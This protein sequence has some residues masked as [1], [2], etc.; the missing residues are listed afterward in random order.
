DRVLQH[1]HTAVGKQKLADSGVVAAELAMPRAHEIVRPLTQVPFGLAGDPGEVAGE[2]AVPNRAL[3]PR[4][5]AL[6]PL[7]LHGVLLADEERVAG[8]IQD[9]AEAGLRLRG[10]D[11]AAAGYR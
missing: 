4:R 9:G 11:L 3:S 7:A 5:T 2:V 8:P 10:G 6:A 1:G